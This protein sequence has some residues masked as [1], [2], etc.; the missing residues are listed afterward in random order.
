MSI[1]QRLKEARISQN[2][3]Q[4][5]LASAIG[6]SKGAIGNYETEVSSPKESILI[7]LM[8][9]LHVDANFL[10]QDYMLSSH[11]LRDD[12]ILMLTAYRNADSRAREDALK[13]LLDHPLKKDEQSAI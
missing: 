10:Y 5:E 3:T 1:G 9:V 7:K 12:E 2:I 4:E 6:V 11:Q 13:T 8:E